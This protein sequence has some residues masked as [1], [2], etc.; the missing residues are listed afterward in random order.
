MAELNAI[1]QREMHM[2]DYLRELDTILAS[3]GRK[4]LDNAGTISAEQAKQKAKAEYQK[5]K[6]KTLSEVEKD[7]LNQIA[8]IEKMAK[9][10]GK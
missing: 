3:T 1:E 10:K 8:Q 2:A 5:Y 6:A 4:V 9:N 7:Y